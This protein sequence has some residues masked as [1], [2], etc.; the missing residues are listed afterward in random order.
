MSDSRRPWKKLPYLL[1][2]FRAESIKVTRR[3]FLSNPS[4]PLPAVLFFI[5]IHSCFNLKFHLLK[6]HSVAW[7]CTGMKLASGSVD[8]TARVWHIEPHGHVYF[9]IALVSLRGVLSVRC[10][11]C[12][13][14]YSNSFL[15]VFYSVLPVGFLFLAKSYLSLTQ[16]AFW[17]LYWLARSLTLVVSRSTFFADKI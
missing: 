3:R 8:Q 2:I 12:G 13:I 5:A 9:I 10:F 11:S 16:V 15:L 17:S 14:L 4:A 1:R 7:N 6:V